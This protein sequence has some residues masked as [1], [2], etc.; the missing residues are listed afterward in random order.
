MGKL[1]VMG[2][3]CQCSMGTGPCS[4][5]VLPTNKVAG[6][7]V[8]AANIQ[9]S[10]P[11]VNLASFIMCTT[12]S[13]PVVAAATAAAMGTP[14]PAPCIPAIAGPWSP[15]AAKTTIGGQP[16][17]DDA[18]TCNCSYGGTIS[19]TSAGQGTIDVA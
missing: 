11:I 7:N 14:T 2:A 10:K 5:V 19:V 8:P 16:A 15:G 1:V 17:L 13:N 18:S 4:L 6:C 12:Q 9:D 3:M